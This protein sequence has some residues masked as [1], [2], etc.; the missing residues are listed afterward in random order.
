[1]GNY[2]CLDTACKIDVTSATREICPCSKPLRYR[3]CDQGYVSTWKDPTSSLAQKP[4]QVCAPKT[5]SFGAAV[6]TKEESQMRKSL[7]KC[8]DYYPPRQRMEYGDEGDDTG[9]PT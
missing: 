9:R 2:S 1:M 5:P 8:P 4:L 3:V 7:S 6:V